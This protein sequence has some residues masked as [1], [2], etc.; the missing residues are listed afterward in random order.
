MKLLSVLTV[1]MGLRAALGIEGE[2]RPTRCDMGMM[3]WI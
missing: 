3:R 2:F 1:F